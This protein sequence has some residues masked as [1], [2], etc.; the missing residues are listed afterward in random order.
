MGQPLRES[1]KHAL[2][3]KVPHDFLRKSYLKQTL[4]LRI[5]DN[6]NRIFIIMKYRSLFLLKFM[7]KNGATLLILIKTIEF[8][9]LR[10]RSRA[11][12]PEGLFGDLAKV[13]TL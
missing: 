9:S 12:Y 3:S 11:D 8:L 4:L 5:T 1:Y 13:G 7:F 6:L 2:M 10:R